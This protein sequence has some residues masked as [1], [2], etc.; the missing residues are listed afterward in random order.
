[1]LAGGKRVIITIPASLREH[2]L[3]TT[4]P[5]E[6]AGEASMSGVTGSTSGEAD[7]ASLDAHQLA[8]SR[9]KTGPLVPLQ[10]GPQERGAGQEVGIEAAAAPGTNHHQS[11]GQHSELPAGREG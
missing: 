10:D 4:N 9:Q 1:M 3:I 6:R 11:S 7:G 5:V 2:A 8:L